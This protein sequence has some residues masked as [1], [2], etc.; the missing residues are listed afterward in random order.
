MKLYFSGYPSFFLFDVDIYIS[1]GERVL[2]QRPVRCVSL[3]H[4]SSPNGLRIF[5]ALL[6]FDT[7]Y[8]HISFEFFPC[9]EPGVSDPPHAVCCLHVSPPFFDLSFFPSSFIGVAK[10][11]PPVFIRE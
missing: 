5:Q 8:R 6:D 11:P 7:R 4:P 3:E 9:V 2:R 1:L 10:S